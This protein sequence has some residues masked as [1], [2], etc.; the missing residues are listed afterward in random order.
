MFIISPGRSGST[1]LQRYLNSSKDLLIWGEHGGFISGLSDS[2]YK[3]ANNQGVQNL[4][5]WGR[6]NVDLLL[7]QQKLVEVDIEWTNNFTLEDWQVAH[8]DLVLRL[9]AIEIPQSVRWGF[10]EIRYGEKVIRLLRE[11]FPKAQ[12]IF[13]VR[14]PID[15]LASMIAAWFKPENVWEQQGWLKDKELLLKLQEF[16]IQHCSRVLRVSEAINRYVADGYLIQYENLKENPYEVLYSTCVYLDVSPPSAEQIAMIASDV[17]KSTKSK[18]IKEAL[19]KEFI[20]NVKI[21]EVCELYEAFGYSCS[22]RKP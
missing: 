3:F 6:G 2:Y 12:F 19:Y 16:I 11:L 21:L 17:R 8:R 4:L 9:L 20:N 5:S 18:A 1:L 15:T 10:K 22:I 7:S 14:H 13:L